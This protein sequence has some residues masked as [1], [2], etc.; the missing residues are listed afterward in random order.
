MFVKGTLL[1]Y[2]TYTQERKRVRYFKY[3]VY[4]SL[5]NLNLSWTPPTL[6]PHKITFSPQH[7]HTKMNSFRT[8]WKV[9][10]ATSEESFGSERMECM[11]YFLD[12][13][14][15]DLPTN[16]K[17]YG[18][19]WVSDDVN[20]KVISFISFDCDRLQRLLNTD[21]LNMLSKTQKAML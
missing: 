12:S 10:P 1:L 5:H 16:T 9:I 17:R 18:I 3:S 2:R 7:Y 4:K 14:G 19:Q 11:I 21:V 20:K 13:D 15:T 6:S 8:E